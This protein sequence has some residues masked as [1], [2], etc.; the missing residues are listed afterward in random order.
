VKI[1]SA[2]VSFTFRILCS[3]LDAIRHKDKGI[4]LLASEERN[5]GRFVALLNA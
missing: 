5:M 1:F 3:V 4:F 2:E